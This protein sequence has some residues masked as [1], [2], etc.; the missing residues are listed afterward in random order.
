M[1]NTPPGMATEP[2]LHHPNVRTE[3]ESK[4]GLYCFKDSARPCAAE[5][6]AFITPPDGPDYKD[7][8]WA[9]CL[10][11]VNEHRMGK[12]LVVLAAGV[13]ELLQ[14]RKKAAADVARTNQP[15]VP[16]VR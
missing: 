8:Q 7:Q 4:T 2:H 5:C 16:P 9:R 12:H 1:S 15:A 10:I 11:L 6:M 3:P 13:G 14:I